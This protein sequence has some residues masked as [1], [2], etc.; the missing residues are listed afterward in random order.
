MPTRLDPKAAPLT[1]RYGG[2]KADQ[3]VSH[4]N[5]PKPEP[6]VDQK[7]ATQAGRGGIAVATA[8]LY[9]V[10]IGL[11]QQIL[12]TRVLG[13]G[14]YGALSTALS[15]SA[16]VYNPVVTTSIQGT[17]RTVARA[18]DTERPLAIRKAL[19]I[20]AVLAV[21]LCGAFFAAAGPVSRAINAPHLAGA[22]SIL[23]LVLLFYGLY[24]P[25]VGIL[26]GLRRFTWQ[27]GLDM[28]YAT[29]RTVS[30]VGLGYLFTR[31]S[32]R[33]T[34]G[35]S[36][37]FS[38]VAALI[39]LVALPLAGTGK[40]GVSSLS[41]RSYLTFI[42]PVFLGQVWL[43]MLQQSDL[44]LLRYFAAEAALAEGNSVIAAD[45]LVGAYRAS[46]LFCFL[47]YQ[48][49]LSITFVLFPL[50]A[51]AHK[52]QSH[53]QVTLFVRT[54][55][56][57][58]LVIA[59]AMVG[60]ISGLSEGLLRLVFPAEVAVRATQSM[61]LLSLGFGAF[62]VFGILTTVLTSLKRERLS[63]A[64]T[65]FSVLS[66]VGSGVFLLHGQPFDDR[67]LLRTAIATSLGLLLATGVAALAVY[68]VAGGLASPLTL[69]RVLV[70][71][72]V[73]VSTGRLLAPETPVGTVL[74]S[75]VLAM[76][77]FGTLTILRELSVRDLDHVNAVLGRRPGVAR[78]S[79]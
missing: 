33:G 5:Q 52:D 59:G 44:T 2:D 46:Q 77:Y 68:R 11:I 13:T 8:K 51:K 58:A 50:L 20:H 55:L 31:H 37:G 64:I 29:M 67:L 35:A 6:A 61:Q 14:G 45:P 73:T 69:L 27:A 57:M 30:M 32:G 71:L 72:A 75:L 66:V 18:S 43:N 63:A 1:G 19:L 21:T 54:G 48:L 40:R 15:V 47:P 42:G 49:L 74:F 24:A 34:E 38:L 65:G 56:R 22:L 9:F 28:L 17:S 16:I 76:L 41:T 78:S 62:A 10:V 39:V 53:A 3:T 60:V 36:L 7:L 26:N 12:L 4:P 70:A 25:L 79:P 23:S